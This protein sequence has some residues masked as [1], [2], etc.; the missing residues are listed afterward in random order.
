MLY[1]CFFKPLRD[2]LRGFLIAAWAGDK[3]AEFS[4]PEISFHFPLRPWF[5]FVS[6]AYAGKRQF[7]PPAGRTDKDHPRMCGEKMMKAGSNCAMLGSPPAYAGKSLHFPHFL[8]DGKDHPRVCG[9]KGWFERRLQ[10]GWGSPPRMRGKACFIPFPVRKSGIT[11]AYAGKRAGSSGDYSTAGDHPRVC[12]E[13]FCPG[14]VTNSIK[15][16]PPRMRGKDNLT[17]PSWYA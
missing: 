4:F 11:P 9:E 16:S 10:Y 12:G 7:C 5:F 13:K 3:I 8:G 15:G 17:T 14:V 2:H 6:P 1:L